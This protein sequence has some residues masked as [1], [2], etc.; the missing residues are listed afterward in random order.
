MLR[1]KRWRWLLALL[2]VCGGGCM[3]VMNMRDG[4]DPKMG[5][6]NCVPPQSV[7]GGV[8]LDAMTFAGGVADLCTDPTLTAGERL[9]A[10]PY[11][12]LFLADMPLSVVADT[13]TLPVTVRAT[14]S[15]RDQP[16]TQG[17]IPTGQ[18]RTECQPPPPQ[19]S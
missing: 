9:M 7:Y 11:L 10:P 8:R 2:P 3:S 4:E 12:L 16:G 17:L 1:R 6:V 18:W 14:L 19:I 15:R 13:L 5:F